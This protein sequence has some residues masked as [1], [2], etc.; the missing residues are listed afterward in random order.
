MAEGVIS[1]LGSAR[2]LVVHIQPDIA[3][4]VRTADP[5]PPRGYG[6]IA[7]RNGGAAVQGQ[8]RDHHIVL[9]RAG[10]FGRVERG[11]ATHEI[12]ARSDVGD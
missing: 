10:G 5:G 7:I 6:E 9:G 3:A 1:R 12:G 2:Y 8:G 11:S 4:V